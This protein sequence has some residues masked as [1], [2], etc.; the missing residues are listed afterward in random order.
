MTNAFDGEEARVGGDHDQRE[1]RQG[2]FF[3]EKSSRE[4]KDASD[5][6]SKKEK[7]CKSG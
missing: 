4:T 5:R 3:E 6:E 7:R 1:Q 2:H